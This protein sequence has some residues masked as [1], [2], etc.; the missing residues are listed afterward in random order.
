MKDFSLKKI[1]R[2]RG[3]DAAFFQFTNWRKVHRGRKKSMFSYRR[4]LHRAEANAEIAWSSVKKSNGH[5]FLAL[6]IIVFLP[7]TEVERE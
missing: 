1:E 7:E 2:E 3:R 5:Y 4:Y 6:S